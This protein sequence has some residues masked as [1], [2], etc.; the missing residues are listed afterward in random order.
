MK[1]KILISQPWSKDHVPHIDNFINELENK[2]CEVVL[3]PKTSKMYEDDLRIWLKGFYAHICGSDDWT[4]EVMDDLGDIK[5]ISRIGVGFD[6][7]DITAA[8]KRGIAV[9]TT[10][11]AGAETV[12]EYAFT[13]IAAM[14]RKIM[15]N[16]QIVRSGKW[17]TVIGM[18][19]YRKTLGIIGFGLIGKQL[20][21]WAQG[22]GMKVIAYDPIIDSSYAEKN[23]IAYKTLDELLSK[24]DY[25]SLHL[26]LMESTK[27]LISEREL[28][29]MKPSAQ[30][31]NASRGGIINELD[32]YNALKNGIIDAAALDVFVE[33]PINMDNP[34]LS[35]DNVIFT[36]HMAGS[37]YEGLDSIVGAAIHNVIDII[38]GK[39]PLGIRNPEVLK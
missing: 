21:R 11:G 34:L 29:L 15:Q 33:E 6:S 13:M 36:P 39:V 17:D 20:A 38:D 2:N 31:V 23:N 32:L 9:T 22:F 7:V 1:K 10:P 3:Y 18:S 27:N 19:V 16:N 8:T 12:S 35:L 28:S 30:I 26:P 14:S 5:V 4:A 37:T 25:I 24:S